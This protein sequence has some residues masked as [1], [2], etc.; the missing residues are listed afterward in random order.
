MSRVALA[1]CVA[2][3]LSACSPDP[4]P[5]AGT[6]LIEERLA[7]HVGV[8]AY[9]YGFPAVDMYRRMHN[10]THRVSEDQSLYAPLNT[11]AQVGK[12]SWA[13]WL[14][15]RAGSLR[16]R[17]TAPPGCRFELVATD[18]YG[19]RFRKTEVIGAP[20]TAWVA[21]HSGVGS[22][23]G[24]ALDTGTPRAKIEIRADRALQPGAASLDGAA[25]PSDEIRIA[26]LEPMRSLGFFEVLNTLLKQ[27]PTPPA[28]AL[29]LEQFDSVGIGPGRDFS[30]AELSP[31]RKRGL[32]RAIRDAR[33][34]L[35]AARASRPDGIGLSRDVLARAAAYAATA[36]AAIASETSTAA[37][38]R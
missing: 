24:N 33:S 23:A 29:L 8:L 31:A 18:F 32:E 20:G 34:L 37:D 7:Y 38:S 35:T 36:E 21:L 16:V 27:L 22:V 30:L 25:V 17:L 14:D 10:E 2:L 15:A 6:A 3:L 4:Q 9:L 19:R 28:D 26:A 12:D 1:L 11:L 5:R 13:G